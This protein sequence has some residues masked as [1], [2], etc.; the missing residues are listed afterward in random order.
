MKREVKKIVCFI[1]LLIIFTAALT[2]LVFQKM[3]PLWKEL[4]VI[5]FKVFANIKL[6]F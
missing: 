6:N 3:F 4:F 5:K 1:I 2:A